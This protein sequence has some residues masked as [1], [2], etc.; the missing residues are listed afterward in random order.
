MLLV[1]IVAGLFCFIY[2]IVNIYYTGHATGV[3]REPAS[4]SYYTWF[5]VLFTAIIHEFI[6]IAPNII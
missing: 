5:R 2:F 1:T 4:E 6:L 3:L